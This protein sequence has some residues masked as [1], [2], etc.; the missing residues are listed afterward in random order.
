VSDATLDR[1]TWRIESVAVEDPRAVALRGLLDAD[2]G[3]RYRRLND[4]ESPQRR[5]EREEALR[6]HPEQVVATLLAVETDGTPAGHVL[7]RRLGEERELKR[8][9]VPPEFRGRGIA[10]ALVAE[11]IAAARADGGHRLILQTGAMQP[12]SIALYESAGFTRIP[13]Y[14]PYVRT[15]PRSICFALLL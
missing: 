11:T 4:A 8:L 6:V 1:R 7:L 12:E 13:V 15:M 10:R 14:E 9:I 3:E 5:A 2:L